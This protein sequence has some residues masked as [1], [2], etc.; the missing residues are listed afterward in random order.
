MRK[1]PLL[2]FC[3][4]C[5]LLLSSAAAAARVQSFSLES[6]YAVP[7]GGVA[8]IVAG[9]PDGLFLFYTNAS[10]GKVGVLD[11]SD[12]QKPLAAADISVDGAEPTSASV[13]RDGNYLVVAARN[14]DGL[15]KPAP[16][17][18]F[19]YDISDRASPRLLGRAE[20]GV[21]PDSVAL[22]ERGGKVAAIVAI[23]DEET[24]SEGE[25]TIGGQRPGRVDL[26]ILNFENPA[27]SIVK[28][29]DFPKTALEG[30]GG[31]NFPSD[32]QPEFIAVR[33]DQLEFAVTL[34]EN[35][36]VAVVDIENFESPRIKTIFCAGA[37]ERSA[38]LRKDGRA[39]FSE[40]FKGRREP[41]GIAYV[42]AGS[43]S[44]LAL[45][46]EGD[47]S[48]KTFG[49]GV[50]SGGRG[51]SLH[52]LDGAP[53]W[54]SGLELE[55]A[56]SLLGHYPDSRSNSRSLEV[57]G[58]IGAR[59]F[60]DDL[61]LAVSERGSFIAVY[62]LSDPSRPELI[63]I[64]PTG[65]SPE[66]VAVL[67]GRADGKNLIVTANEGDGT[68]N[69]Y[70]ASDGPG[71]PD[72]KNPAIYSK[73]VPWSA[74][75]GFATDGRDIYSVPDNA[76]SPS[77]IWKLDMRGAA[78]GRVEITE[79]IP[80]T[81]GGAPAAYDLEGIC[82]TKEG[83]W[84]VSEGSESA[85]NILIFASHDG[86][87][88]MERPLPPEFISKYGDSKNYGFEGV[89]AAADGKIYA[90]FQRGFD[91]GGAEAAILRFDPAS[92]EWQAA[93]YPL[94]AHSKDP[95]KFWMGLSDISAL[96]DGRLLV[97]ERD[98]GMG[99]TAEVKRIYSVDTKA[100]ESDGR[101]EKRLVYDILRER[102]LLLEKVESLCVLDG[103]MWIAN[104]NDGA[105]W[106]QML[107]LGPVP[108]Q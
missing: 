16:G 7:G 1:I 21:G 96:D 52:R 38:D 32:P 58:V 103:E 9:T 40:A 104:D 24:D 8:E 83:F 61:M 65:L 91:L 74:L 15:D 87:V 31:V 12:P 94:E 55:I 56:A 51:L 66:G 76:R 95:K 34:Q 5:A 20:V 48:L 28:S 10:G 100:F 60:D 101:L 13:S 105:G 98:K 54:D 50:S 72:R 80:L 81:K 84:L 42:N 18:L 37:A 59:L 47:T 26:V 92:E 19:V 44:Y 46:N 99:G 2:P 69:I 108:K 39:E 82:W 49:D 90:A 33:P 30:V 63:G 68:V 3:L 97:V 102:N 25:A 29:V 78:S 85:G 73:S 53:V 23:E 35:N 64:L 79:E 86:K 36:A 89:A 71:S 43:E 107:N 67:A 14:G 4:F 17:S 11:I 77:V 41:D 62:R 27:A 93:W 6:H 57:E 75:S 106:T 45:A 70:S 88:E 22:A